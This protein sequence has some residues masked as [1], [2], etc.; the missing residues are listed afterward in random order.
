MATDVCFNCGEDLPL[1]LAT[2]P[3]CGASHRV[4][5]T[6]REI[7]LFRIVGYIAATLAFILVLVAAVQ[8]FQRSF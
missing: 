6:G 3:R 7:H 1:G 5:R 8:W 4:P 2:C